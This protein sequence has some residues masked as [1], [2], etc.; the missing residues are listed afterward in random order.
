MSTTWELDFYSCPILDEQQKKLWE[1]LICES[2]LDIK[3]E[4]DSLFRYAQFCPSNQVNSASLREAIEAAIEQA[5]CPP[6]KIRFFRRQMTNMITKACED[7]GIPVY[8]SRRTIGLHQWMEDRE[9]NYYPTLPNYQAKATNPSVV[10]PF[11][12]PA[13]LPDALIGQQWAF[14]TLEASAFA[15][16]PDWDI[17]FGESFPLDMAGVSAEMRI[18]GVIIFSPRALP[19]AGWMSGLD[20]AYL[21]YETQSGGNSYRAPIPRLLLETGSSESWVLANLTTD[22]QQIEAKN[23][24]QAKRDAQ[25][26]HFLAVQSDPNSE[27]FAGFWLLQELNLA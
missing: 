10:L 19:L 6:D 12:N 8:G 15:D 22:A 21:R 24:E 27:A 26:V 4:T 13:Q 9:Q 18:P 3:A 5:P 17:G 7:A 20:V 2:P 23:F 16:L 25:N 1:V 14:V 11:P